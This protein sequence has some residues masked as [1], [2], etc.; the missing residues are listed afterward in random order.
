MNGSSGE[1]GLQARQELNQ[2]CERSDFLDKKE[3]NRL[4]DQGNHSQAW[5]LLNFALWWKEYLA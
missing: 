4:L 2:C 3:V 1:L 5:Y